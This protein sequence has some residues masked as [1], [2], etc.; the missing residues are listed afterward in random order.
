MR[1]IKNKQPLFDADTVNIIKACSIEDQEQFSCMVQQI[2]QCFTQNPKERNRAVLLVHA[3]GE[4]F[5]VI[6][7]NTDELE[8]CNMLILCQDMMNTK[9]ME[10]AP[11]MENRH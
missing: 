7:A 3:P 8:A 9:V 5:R 10:D 2:A 6:S 1:E 4:V 11:P